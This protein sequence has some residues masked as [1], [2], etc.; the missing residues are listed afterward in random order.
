MYVPDYWCG[1]YCAL[2]VVSVLIVVVCVITLSAYLITS[3]RGPQTN[4][5]A[6]CWSSKR[7]VAGS[8]LST[9]YPFSTPSSALT[10][11]YRNTLVD[12]AALH[13]GTSAP[14]SDWYQQQ[15]AALLQ[16]CITF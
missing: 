8:G 16:V 5:L 14:P 4:L 12:S 13:S 3:R 6:S 7:Y 2:L 11:Q 10:V 1:D 9:E 15:L